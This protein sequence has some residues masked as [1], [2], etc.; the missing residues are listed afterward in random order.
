MQNTSNTRFTGCPENNENVS[1]FGLKQNNLMHPQTA[2]CN[3]FCRLY[4]AAN[5]AL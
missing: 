1:N 2:I 3:I 5:V 4:S